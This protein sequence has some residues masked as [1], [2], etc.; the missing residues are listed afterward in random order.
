MCIVFTKQTSYLK[1]DID[2]MNKNLQAYCSND[3]I[4]AGLAVRDCDYYYSLSVDNTPVRFLV[5]KIVDD[6]TYSDSGQSD[7]QSFE[8]IAG[9][10]SEFQKRG[11][12]KAALTELLSNISTYICIMTS[13]I[14]LDVLIR[15]DNPLCDKIN[16]L[17]RSDHLNFMK[18]S[19]E[20]DYYLTKAIRVNN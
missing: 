19:N 9:I 7:Y 14:F 1:R 3:F 5:L 13:K 12:L 4:K 10:Y 6:D 20:A 2:F 18:I 16:S 17:L 11:Y 8:I 15:K